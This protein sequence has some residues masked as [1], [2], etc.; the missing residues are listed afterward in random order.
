[1]STIPTPAPSLGLRYRRPATT[2]EVLATHERL[3]RYVHGHFRRKL[4]FE[5]ARDVAAEALA[6]AD[7]ATNAG[8]DIADLERWLRRAAWRNALDV[9]RKVEGEAK[10]PRQRPTDIADHAERLGTPTTEHDEL[11]SATALTDD[12]RALTAAFAAL[13]PDEHR[14]LRLRYFDELA[15]DEVLAVM[16]CSRHHYENLHKRGLRKLRDALVDH[17]ADASCAECRTLVI[18][19]QDAA[20]DG[21]AASRRDAHLEG[22]LTCR[23]FAGRK[24]GLLASLPLPALGLADRFTTQLHA[25]LA[26]M[27]DPSQHAEGLAGSVAVG[28]G[29]AGTLAGGGA[30]LFGTVGTAKTVAVICSAGAVTASVC[31]T[32]PSTQRPKRDEPRREHRAAKRVQT[33]T[34]TPAAVAPQVT[35]VASIERKPDP[36]PPPPK[37]KPKRARQTA[38]ERREAAEV[39][40]FLPEAAADPAPPSATTASASTTTYSAAPDSAPRAKPKSA[41]ASAD[42]F[43]DE[44]TP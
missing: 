28:A 14:A 21:E 13:K 37:A 2:D 16:G 10:E 42:A 9:I 5:E 36:S 17:T 35:A 15:V 29:S 41:S 12:A 22:C 31:V 1:M 43:S 11:V 4:S 3:A 8:H 7:K 44:F 40:P 27:P 32:Q 26:G 19:A 38:S 23:A 25:R 33:P 24:A 30:T 18:A 34:A 20:L 6:E 39:T